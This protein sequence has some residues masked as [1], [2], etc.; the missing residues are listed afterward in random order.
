MTTKRNIPRTSTG[1][2]AERRNEQIKCIQINLQHSR[3]ATDNLIQ[4]IAT[5]NTDITLV[6]EPYLYRD[7]IKGVTRKY[8]TYSYGEGKRRATIIIANNKI[9]ALLITQH[10]KTPFSWKY[11]KRKKN[12]TQLAYIWTT[13]R[14]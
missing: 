3:T 7:E 9:D 1:N 8:R 13:T 14:Q 2:M 5:E 6:Q 4:I 11:N 10:S 12:F